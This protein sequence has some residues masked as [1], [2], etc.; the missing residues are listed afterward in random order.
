MFYHATDKVRVYEEASLLFEQKKEKD[1]GLFFSSYFRFL[2]TKA[3]TTAIMM[4][5]TAPMATY[6]MTGVPLVGGTTTGLGVGAMVA[7]G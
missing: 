7:V 2:K 5:T 6:V 4:I 1:G 3:A